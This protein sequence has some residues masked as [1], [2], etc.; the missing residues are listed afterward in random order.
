MSNDAIKVYDT[1]EPSFFS[2]A[3]PWILGVL[4]LA[5]GIGGYVYYV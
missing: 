5:M 2:K 3:F 4:L 1:P